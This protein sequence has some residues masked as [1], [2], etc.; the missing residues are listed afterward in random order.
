MLYKKLFDEL[1]EG[2]FDDVMMFKTLDLNPILEFSKELT[3]FIKL[4]LKEIREFNLK[5]LMN[6][7]IDRFRKVGKSYDILEVHYILQEN[8]SNLNFKYTNYDEN[9]L[10]KYLY[11]TTTYWKGNRN[12]E[13][14]PIEEAWK[15]QICEFADDCDWRKKKIIELQRSKRSLNK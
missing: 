2:K 15:C 13:D 7:V 11:N 6:I 10:T 5:S 12:P 3:D 1:A 4:N 8:R 14:V 9:K